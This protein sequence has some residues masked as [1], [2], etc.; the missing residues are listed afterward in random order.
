VPWEVEVDG[1][2]AILYQLALAISDRDLA[3]IKRGDAVVLAGSRLDAFD[4]PCSVRREAERILSLLSSAARLLFGSTVSL[5]P[6]RILERNPDERGPCACDD[7]HA[8]SRRSSLSASVR[9][10]LTTPAMEIALRH[11]DGEPS[12]ADFIRIYD[13]VENA[14]GGR[15]ATAALCGVSVATIVRLHREHP[16]RQAPMTL[17][18]TRRVVD[19]VLMAWLGSC[20]RAIGNRKS[21]IG[22]RNA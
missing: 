17:E 19:R 5:R 9:E 10:A 21:E 8:W 20:G 7:P 16:T 22:N 12:K 4:E 1:P 3:L 11:R 2:D 13:I 15:R 18:E 6:G 14:V